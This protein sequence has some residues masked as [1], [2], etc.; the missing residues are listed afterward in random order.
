[1]DLLEGFEILLGTY[2]AFLIGYKVKPSERLG[3]DGEM[4]QELQI[5]FAN[6]AHS[7][8]VR[9][10]AAGDKY[11]ISAG[12]D[13]NVKIFNLR[14]RTEHG[15]LNHADGVIN[16]MLFFDK[17]H[18]ITASED[19]KICILKAN[20]GW[21][22]EKTLSKHKAGVTD[23]A[24]H[25]S[26]KLMLS[27]GKDAKLITWNLIKGRSAYVTNLHENA[28]FVQWSPSGNYYAVGFYKRLDIYSVSTAAIEV[29]LPFPGRLNEVIFLDD[30]TIAVAG[31]MSHIEVHSIVSK[32]LIMKFEAHTNRVRCM[33]LV[34]EPTSVNVGSTTDTTHQCLVTAS[35]DG[36]V[37][38]W[39]LSKKPSEEQDGVDKDMN[40]SLKFTFDAKEEA[41]VDTKFR[42]T[43]LKV[44]KVPQVINAS[45]QVK[46][47]KRDAEHS[48]KLSMDVN[49]K[50][51][52]QISNYSVLD[53]KE[54]SSQ[55]GKLKKK[56]KVIM[57]DEMVVGTD[58]K[59]TK[60][61]VT[62]NA[63][64]YPSKKKKKVL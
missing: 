6:H 40:G 4:L 21:N 37:K 45:V 14:N 46:N 10:I 61:A 58:D 50:N 59:N 29:S 36:L 19:G 25:P 8:S 38:I 55:S 33:S 23:L 53:S 35:N 7:A 12:G 2:E 44:H 49:E 24:L 32:R 11:L 5:S 17:K 64:K 60:E 20:S 51:K 1:M 47:K 13:E 3:K 39:R 15:A 34:A 31:E 52:V 42:V 43:C 41:K 18:L 28:D 30:V 22:V 26:G 54:N 56:S 57:E 27:I 62:E 63:E 16:C 9:S 48:A